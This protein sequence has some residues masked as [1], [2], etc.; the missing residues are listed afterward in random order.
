M[1]KTWLFARTEVRNSLGRKTFVFFAFGLPILIGI[2]AIGFAFF[3]R[4]NGEPKTADVLVESPEP[5]DVGYVDPGGHIQ[6]L[7]ENVPTDWLKPYPDQDAALLAL[8]DGEIRGFYFIPEDYVAAGELSLVKLTHNPMSTEPTETFQW[9]LLYN[10]AGGDQALATS[11]WAPLDLT[12]TSIAPPSEDSGEETWI[13][14]MLPTLMTLILYMVIIMTSQILINAISDEKKNRVMEIVL[15]SASSNQ[16][17]SGKILAGGILGLMMIFTWL[18]IFWM[19]ST[20]GGASLNIPADFELPINLLVWAVVYAFLG[21]AMYG[22]LMAGLGALSPDV[23]DARSMSMI[24]LLPLIFGY[25]LNVF[26]QINPDGPIAVIASLFPLTAPV[27]MI[28]RMTVTE[29]PVWQAA[30]AAVLMVAAAAL[31]IR[32]VAHFFRA[33]ILL[34]GQQPTP[35][36]FFKTLLGRAT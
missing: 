4:D 17:I 27:T 3:N 36:R 31:I 32:L 25:M 19:V 16:F 23:K 28:I 7:P 8:E 1:N 34:S 21:Y 29:V 24:I 9:I 2:V 20:F 5:T 14:E 13:T 12:L 26:I 6:T 11:L 22:S 30:L 33:Q 35:K 10:M 15:S 18:G